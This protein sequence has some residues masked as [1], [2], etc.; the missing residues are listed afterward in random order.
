LFQHGPVHGV[1]RV[2]KRPGVVHALGRL[3]RIVVPAAR[4]IEL[5]DGLRLV[6][7]ETRLDVVLLGIDVDPAVLVAALLEFARGLVGS[8]S[9]LCPRRTCSAR[10]QQ[11]C[12][13]KGRFQETTPALRIPMPH[14]SHGALRRCSFSASRSS[15]VATVWRWAR[16]GC[17]LACRLAANLGTT[18]GTQE[19]AGG[20]QGVELAIMAAAATRYGPA[21]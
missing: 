1:K 4:A 19:T 2:R 6:G 17:R 10:K 5:A 18:S 16:S 13:T 20:A 9:W 11:N 8:P 3:R 12:A 7:P 14:F 15:V 21:R